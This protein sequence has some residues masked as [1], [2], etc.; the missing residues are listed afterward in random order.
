MLLYAASDLAG[1]RRARS[2][3]GLLQSDSDARALWC[4]VA[5]LLCSVRVALLL[6][7]AVDVCLVYAGLE[8]AQVVLHMQD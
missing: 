2:I 7:R 5:A 3:G 4:L 1:C 8:L 6:L